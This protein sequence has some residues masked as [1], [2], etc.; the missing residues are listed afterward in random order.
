MFSSWNYLIDGSTAS[1]GWNTVSGAPAS[2]ISAIPGSFP[3]ATGVTQY[4]YKKFTTTSLSDYSIL[5]VS[6][7]TCDGMIVY[8]NGKKIHSRNMLPMRWIVSLLLQRN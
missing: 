2:W 6:M 8:M 7:I 1:E 5:E 4:Y 3:V